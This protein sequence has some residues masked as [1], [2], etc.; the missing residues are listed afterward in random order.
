MKKLLFALIAISILTGCKTEKE[1]SK[2]VINVS[3]LKTYFQNSNLPAGIMGFSTREG[4]IGWYAFG[5]SIW[6]GKDTINENNIFRIYSMTK[7]IASVAALQLVEKGLIGLDA[8]LDEL[9]PE[10]TSIPIL[11]KEGE[12]VKASKTITLRN[13]LTHT[14]GFGYDFFD[15]QLQKFDTTGWEYDDLPRLFE[16]GEKWHYG[17]NTDWVGKIVEKI[18]GKN[19]EDYFRENI[20]GPLKMNSTW[21]NV[22][23]NLKEN[24]VSWGTRDSSGFKEYPRIPVAP[25]SEFIAG[26]G[27]FGSPK[28][29]L[30]FL[31]CIMNYGKYDGGQILKS[32][33]VELMFK[34]ALPKDLTLNFDLPDEGLPETLGHFPDESD[35]FS[36]SWAIEN[37]NDEMVRTKGSVY[38]AGV[39]NSYYTLD[40]DKG[41][42]IVYFTQFLPFN[43]KVSYDFYRLFEK[44][45]YTSLNTK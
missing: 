45:V 35:L 28:D 22:P 5:P 38:W 17:R 41:I 26:E 32:E 6:G 11:T 33:T 16:A 23:E 3:P 19:L 27:L 2:V 4:K 36:L 25:V 9:M 42:A 44:E 1:G 43:D 13:L 8:P 39:A 12:L 29:Y 40:K 37:S 21:F 10:M 30:T 31:N 18:S 7:A 15:D 24:I 20:T 34:N 14:A